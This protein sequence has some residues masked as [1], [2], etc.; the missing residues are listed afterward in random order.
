MTVCWRLVFYYSIKV[1]RPEAAPWSPTVH[2]GV[3]SKTKD[4]LYLIE[5]I[6]MK[7]WQARLGS[8]ENIQT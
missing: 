1:V 5:Q 6:P 4:N 7:A 3:Q 2:Q 8:Q